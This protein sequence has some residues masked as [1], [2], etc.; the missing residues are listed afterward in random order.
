MKVDDK[1]YSSDMMNL[2]DLVLQIVFRKSFTSDI[3]SILND[4]RI[5]IVIN[6]T[7]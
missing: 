1:I 7:E 6:L 2:I 5:V 4:L 3:N